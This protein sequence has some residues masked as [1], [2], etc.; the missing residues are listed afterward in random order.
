MDTIKLGELISGDRSESIPYVFSV[1]DK[2]SLSNIKLLFEGCYYEEEGEEILDENLVLLIGRDAEMYQH[3]IL[4][5]GDGFGIGGP[6]TP[7]LQTDPIFLAIE[8]ENEYTSPGTRAV[9]IG[10]A[11]EVP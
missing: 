1:S 10:F 6:L 7:E 8:N 5:P 3:V 9:K 2:P 4:H 11:Y